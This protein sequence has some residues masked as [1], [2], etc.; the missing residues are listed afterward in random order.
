MAMLNECVHCLQEGIV[1]EPRDIDV[2]VIFGL[3]FP[4]FRG[5]IL[6]YADSR[7]LGDIVETMHRLAD[8]YGDRLR[9]AGLLE[10]KASAGESFY[11]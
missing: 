8:E 4:P 10:Q 7:G 3:G 1:E 11:Q 9:P 6:R 5:G 2:G